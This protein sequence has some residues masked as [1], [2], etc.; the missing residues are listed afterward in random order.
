MDP[1]KCNTKKSTWKKLYRQK[2]SNPKKGVP[3]K[4]VYPQKQVHPQKISNPKKV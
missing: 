4:K 1:K 2:M 3:S